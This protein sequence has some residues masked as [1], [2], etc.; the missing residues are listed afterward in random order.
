DDTGNDMRLVWNGPSGCGSDQ[1]SQAG[2]ERGHERRVTGV[3]VTLTTSLVDCGI[4]CL[5]NGVAF[6][7]GEAPNRV[8]ARTIVG[9]RNHLQPEHH[10]KNESRC[11]KGHQHRDPLQFV[12]LSLSHPS[13]QTPILSAML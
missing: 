12:D 10:T 4:G 9:S 2:Q 8:P 5:V 1:P 11:N 7:I 3:E 6:A 13:Y